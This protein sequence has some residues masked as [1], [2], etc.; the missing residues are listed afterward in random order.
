LWASLPLA[1][2]AIPFLLRR[3]THADLMLL[4]CFAAIVIGHIGTKG[5]GLHGFGPRY[6]FDVFF[7]LYLLTAR[8][9]QELGRSCSEPLR[10]H[11]GLRLNPAPAIAA[12]A[13]FIGLAVSTAVSLPQRLALYRGYNNVNGK[14]I[15]QMDEL[16]LER[17]L[18]VF[19]EEDWRNWAGAAPRMTADA[20]GADLVFGVSLDDN[21]KL[22]ELAGDRPVYIWRDQTLEPYQNSREP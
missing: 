1:F 17:A 3:H 9:F 20:D 7:A 10:D 22:F 13:L 16:G 2:A 18:V 19:A 4:G 8:G 21:T 14:L 12:V 15:Q 11:D 5:H 6:Y